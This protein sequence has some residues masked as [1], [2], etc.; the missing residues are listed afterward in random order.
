MMN[1]DSLLG[2][3]VE[4][5]KVILVRMTNGAS[6]WGGA[7][8]ELGE[9][10]DSGHGQNGRTSDLFAILHALPFSSFPGTCVILG[11][12]C[13]REYVQMLLASA[14]Q[15]RTGE[16]FMRTED[17]GEDFQINHSVLE[18][19]SRDRCKVVPKRVVVVPECDQTWVHAWVI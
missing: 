15:R 7:H 2:Y 10:C 9:G 19:G 11:L 13:R 3:N 8:L 1:K 6:V 4:K 12:N 17:T 18:G 5:E 14:Y 16:L